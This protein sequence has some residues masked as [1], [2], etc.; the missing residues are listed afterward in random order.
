MSGAPREGAKGDGET[1]L[2]VALEHAHNYAH[3]T[4]YPLVRRKE[5]ERILDALAA[6]KAAREAAEGERDRLLA[7]KT[8]LLTAIFQF[9]SHI[10]L[11]YKQMTG[12]PIPE[13]ENAFCDAW[14]M[15][16]EK[17]EMIPPMESP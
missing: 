5:V 4:T 17:E 8:E 13:Q 11:I 9:G 7:E 14:V 2:D 6:E 3:T 10:G 12:L 15:D 1:L 16:A